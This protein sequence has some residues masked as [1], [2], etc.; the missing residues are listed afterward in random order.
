VRFHKGW[1]GLKAKS[2]AKRHTLSDRV[3]KEGHFVAL[4]MKAKVIFA[5]FLSTHLDLKIEMTGN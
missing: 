4:L 2:A 3:K 5:I 1:N